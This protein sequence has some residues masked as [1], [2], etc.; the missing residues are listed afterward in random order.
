MKFAGF[1]VG[2]VAAFLAF[3]STLSER[4]R[5]EAA[6]YALRACRYEAHA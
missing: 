6:L 4:S 5:L 1:V 3:Q 2:F